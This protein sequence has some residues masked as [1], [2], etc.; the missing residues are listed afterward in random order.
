MT[1][2]TAKLIFSKSCFYHDIFFATR[3]KVLWKN[4]KS[5][6]LSVLAVLIGWSTLHFLVTGDVG[7][8]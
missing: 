4:E 3:T 5:A 8:S 7:S 1:T 2:F 6:M